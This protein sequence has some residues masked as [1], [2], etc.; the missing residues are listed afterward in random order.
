[1]NSQ[2]PNVAHQVQWNAASGPKMK[3]RQFFANANWAQQIHSVDISTSGA[4]GGV[5][6]LYKKKPNSQAAEALPAFVVK[7]TVAP[8]RMLFAEHLLKTIA[9]AKIPKSLS[10]YLDWTDPLCPG[11][12]LMRLLQDQSNWRFIANPTR[13]FVLNQAKKDKYEQGFLQTIANDYQAGSYS[14]L[15]IMKAFT[16]AHSLMDPSPFDEW[17]IAA[18]Y[19]K[20]VPPGAPDEASPSTT[21]QTIVQDDKLKNVALRTKLLGLMRRCNQTKGI[22]SSAHWTQYL[23]WILAADT[24]AGNADRVEQLNVGNLFFF[25]KP[26]ADPNKTNPIAVIDND[27]LMPQFNYELHPNIKANTNSW[28]NA[29]SASVVDRYLRFALGTGTELP[30]PGG[31]QGSAIQLAP[32]S[33]LER[34]FTKFDV[35]FSIFFDRIMSTENNYELLTTLYADNGTLARRL[36][37][38]Y[39]QPG[40][41][42]S[43]S[44]DINSPEWQAVKANI[45]HGLVDALEFLQNDPNFFTECQQQYLDLVSYYED[46]QDLNFDFT[47]FLARYHYLQ[48]I[49]INPA[50]G[51]FT[52]PDHN[53]VVAEVKRRVFDAKP[54]DPYVAAI[55]L[56][57]K[58]QGIL[59]ADEV[60]TYQDYLATLDTVDQPQHIT[61]PKRQSHSWTEPGLV[62][63]AAGWE[64]PNA[65]GYLKSAGA[66]NPLKLINDAI[67]NSNAAVAGASLGKK[68]AIQ[69]IDP[70]KW[71]L[72]DE[73]NG[74]TVRVQADK[75][76]QFNVQWDVYGMRTLAANAVLLKYFGRRLGQEAAAQN[77]SLL[78]FPPAGLVWHVVLPEVRRMRQALL[79]GEAFKWEPKKSAQRVMNVLRLETG[80]DLYR[81]Y[82][83]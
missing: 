4:K 35:L 78:P 43:F 71:I 1:M 16:G 3:M 82:K 50:Q 59:T 54:I 55:F 13:G 11:M 75:G 34:V 51:T 47:A 52:A 77:V 18:G 66:N 29:N 37:M 80:V 46:D 20:P 48:Q 72:M 10:V 15:V 23:G 22:L 81:M 21:W 31:L 28:A 12:E 74:L 27:A 17:L 42:D 56:F 83:T 58:N 19:K 64:T 44:N 32:L 7:Y 8:E 69:L 40:G 57:G 41:Y 63:L 76:G 61:L 33:Q 65:Q 38:V 26:S 6:F 24:L 5:V 60:S 9:S 30:P 2:G 68:T 39:V 53:A 73:E 45:V 67:Q 62:P 70:G 36:G 25:V 49:V 79:E 14:Y